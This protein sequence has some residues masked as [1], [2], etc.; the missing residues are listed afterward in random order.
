MNSKCVHRR[1]LLRGMGAVALGLPHLEALANQET[2]SET[3]TKRFVAISAGLGFHAPNLF[4]QMPGRLDTSTPYLESLSDHFD[5]LSLFSGLS[6]PEQQG[7][8]GHASSLTFLTSAQRPGLAGFKNTISIDQQIAKHVGLQTR[9]PFLALSSRGG[10]SLSWT[11]TGV[12]IPGENSPE[13]LFQKLFIAGKPGDVQREIDELQRGRSILD[14]VNRRA[15]QMSPRLSQQDRRKLGEYFSSVRDLEVRLQQQA[16][17]AKRPKPEVD[18]EPLQDIDDKTAAI[19]KQR[20]MYD[21][22]VL[23]L[24]TDSTRV[25]TLELG[26]LNAV[27]KVKGVASDWHGL[28]HHGKDPNKIR[29]LERIELAEFN[30]FSDF[31][32]RLKSIHDNDQ[33]LLDQTAILFGSNLGNASA[34]DWHNLPIVIAGGGFRHGNYIAHDSENNTPLANVFVTMAQHMGVE[35]D[36]FGSST[37]AGIRGLDWA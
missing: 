31:L 12:S 18:A 23:A 24:Q 30:A 2:K 21:L 37:A 28:S 34:H 16:A 19:E 32:E 7:N 17:W 8:N 36:R 26:G 15:E 9:L 35:T 6:H 13:R 20:L 10:S 5:H 33:S 1:G 3:T 27:P 29:E 4:P 11:D 22:I 25:V 14:T